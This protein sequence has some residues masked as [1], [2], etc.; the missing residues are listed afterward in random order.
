MDM[1]QIRL[2]IEY[3]GAGFSGWQAQSAGEPRP[4]APPRSRS[5]TPRGD[6]QSGFVSGRAPK[7]SGRLPVRA[8][9]RTQTGSKNLLQ[10]PRTVQETVEAAI[11]EV[12]GETVRIVGAGR[13]DAGVSA[14]GQVACFRTGTTIPLERIAFALNSKLPRDVAVLASDEAPPE[15]HPRKSAKLKLYR[16][17]ILNRD[18]RPALDRG[19]AWHVTRPLDV[20]RMRAAAGAL[21]GP[22]DFASF[23]TAEAARDKNTTRTISRLEIHRDPA[24][25][26]R[27]LF[28]VEGPGFLMHMIRIIVG[29]LVEVGRGKRP[30]EW[31]AQALRS[32]DRAA[33]GPTAPAAGLTLVEVRYS[34]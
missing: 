20:E 32:R 26:D 34:E 5:P 10:G 17:A 12:T 11:R 31:I 15:F 22:H 3:D 1:K 33:A 9:A 4:N 24:A 23:T 30:P 18:I 14:L 28:E 25:R 6:E 13:T 2:V 21:L 7:R 29:S 27:I 16:Y 19:R 8:V